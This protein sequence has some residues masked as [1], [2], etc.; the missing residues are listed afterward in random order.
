MSPGDTPLP[1]FFFVARRER[2]ACGSERNLRVRE[3]GAGAAFLLWDCSLQ[4]VLQLERV[5]GPRL[6]FRLREAMNGR[7]DKAAITSERKAEP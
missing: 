2:L 6:V 3:Q 4:Q 7:D 5:G 1:G